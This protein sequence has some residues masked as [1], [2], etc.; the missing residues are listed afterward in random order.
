SIIR[1]LISVPDGKVT[2]RGS[3]GGG[4]GGMFSGALLT[5]LVGGGSF[6]GGVGTGVGADAGADP[7]EAVDRVGTAPGA[8]FDV[9]CDGAGAFDAGF[10]T[11]T[12]SSFFSAGRISG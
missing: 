1:T 9:A 7:V 3:G 6:A 4:G 2:C 11:A 10:D 5:T 12:V 8:G